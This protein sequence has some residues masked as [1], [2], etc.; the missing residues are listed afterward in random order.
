M[1]GCVAPETM[2]QCNRGTVNQLSYLCILE[3]QKK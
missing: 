3:S 2:K 1:E